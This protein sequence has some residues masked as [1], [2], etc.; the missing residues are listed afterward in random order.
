MDASVVAR[1]LGIATSFQ[2]MRAGGVLF[3]PQRIA[4]FAQGASASVYATMKQQITSHP[5]AGGLYG[6]GSPI[7]LIARELFPDNGDG[8]GTVPVTVYPLEDA[9][10]A[11]A[12]VAT[13]TPV[14]VVTKS[15]SFR[16]RMAGI[17]SEPFVA[18]T[19][20]SIAQL[21][22]KIT[23][24]IVAVLE[25]P[26]IPSDDTT[27]VGLVA[28][29]AGASGNGIVLE[30]IG[31]TS[32]G[33]TFT[34]VQ[35]NGGLLN[36]DPT[37]ALAEVGNVWESMAI[38]GADIAD[39]DVLDAFQTWGEGR[40]GE[41][42][43]KPL[44]VFTG[45]TLSD[46][47]SATS[48]CSGRREDRIN[49]QLVAPGSVNL[50]CMVAARQ[51]ARIARVANNNPPVDYGAQQA[52]GLLPGSD[53][54]QWDFATRDVAVK[55]G[56][57]T[58]EVSDGIVEIS[59]VVTFYR[60][61]GDPLPAYRFVVDIVKLQN[62]IFNLDLIFAAQEWAGAP[63]IPDDQPTVNPAA[64][65]PKT[66]KTAISAVL[67][68]LGL[69]AII[70]DPKTAKKNTTAVINSQN[71]KRLDMVVPVQLSG[72]TNVKAVDLRFGFFFGA[73]TAA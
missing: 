8:V 31:D 15:A 25:Q 66:A 22:T 40:W 3:L 14:G 26:M 39:T 4:I 63:L 36:P 64:R 37:A 47:T 1:V 69:Q 18:K 65:K 13:I 51:L 17:L 49:S 16:V 24:A 28:K 20:D 57:S 23:A 9:Y 34:L 38:N 11:V 19:T 27:A 41:L 62:I 45:N 60:P 46:E 68:D 59:D 48:V 33:L 56:S 72:N 54:A 30:I 32:L 73:A 43:R 10:E 58:V 6:Y 67:D 7:H 42:V 70:S 21:C 55:A 61:T 35:P 44:I 2:D 50:P 71:P 12:A 5:Q 53:G 52:T 29:W